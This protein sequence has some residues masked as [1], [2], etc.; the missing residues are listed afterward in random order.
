M[1]YLIEVWDV[2][3]VLNR[4]LSQ[5]RTQFADNSDDDTSFSDLLNA[6]RRLTEEKK[7]T[8]YHLE[9]LSNLPE[10][11]ENLL[12]TNVQNYMNDPTFIGMTRSTCSDYSYILFQ[13]TIYIWRTPLLPCLQ[14]VYQNSLSFE[15]C[16]PR[17]SPIIKASLICV[18]P[19]AINNTSIPVVFACNSYGS[20]FY[21]KDPYHEPLLYT[22]NFQ[23]KESRIISVIAML[24][25][26]YY[27]YLCLTDQGDIYEVYYK[28][29]NLIVN[30]KFYFST[31]S[32]SYKIKSYFGNIIGIKQ[33]TK[34]I[35]SPSEYTCL[36]PYLYAPL[37]SFI[38]TR[39]TFSLLSIHKGYKYIYTINLNID[40]QDSIST[41]CQD[42]SYIYVGVLHK[43]DNV[44]HYMLYIYYYLSTS[45]ETYPTFSKCISFPISILEAD[46][47]VVS[48][49]IRLF[50]QSTYISVI[51]PIDFVS[52]Y[53]YNL[54]T[55][56]INEY[57]IPSSPSTFLLGISHLLYP[58]SC[59]HL[60]YNH[61]DMIFV[62]E[63][64]PIEMP[65]NISE[66]L[67]ISTNHLVSLNHDYYDSKELYDYIQL[68]TD[69]IHKENEEFYYSIFKQIIQ[70]F[71]DNHKNS[72][73][74][75]LELF[76]QLFNINI[77]KASYRSLRSIGLSFINSQSTD[78]ESTLLQKVKI[79]Y[80][81]VQEF[82]QFLTNTTSWSHL[83]DIEKQ[84]LLSIFEKLSILK[85]FLTFVTENQLSDL[86]HFVLHQ[87]IT[88]IAPKKQRKNPES[89]YSSFLYNVNN[90]YRLLSILNTMLFSIYSLMNITPSLTRAR[91]SSTSSLT[92]NSSYN[93]SPLTIALS[94]P[95]SMINN[96][97]ITSTILSIFKL[98]TIIF[99]D[100][101][102]NCSLYS[103]TISF[104]N[105]NPNDLLPLY[106]S[107]LECTNQYI[108]HTNDLNNNV[109]IPMII[110]NIIEE[111][112]PINTIETTPLSISDSKNISISD[113]KNISI[114][115]SKNISIS[116][117]KNISISDSFAINN[118]SNMNTLNSTYTSLSF[119]NGITNNQ[120]T[121]ENNNNVDNNNVDNNNVDN[122]N[123]ISDNNISDNNNIHSIDIQNSNNS[124]LIDIKQEKNQP[125]KDIYLQLKEFI[126]ALLKLFDNEF[127][128]KDKD[129]HFSSL[130]NSLLNVSLEEIIDKNYP[131][132]SVTLSRKYHYYPSLYYT[133]KESSQPLK[134]EM[135]KDQQFAEYVAKVKSSN[136]V[137]TTM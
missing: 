17:D 131:A 94:P 83:T 91:S 93:N 123:I 98:Y 90:I 127:T 68:Y 89:F 61:G 53:T 20:I 50:P 100:I 12:R 65:S 84:R 62:S 133:L 110:E 15:V 85:S 22:I 124:T 120:N 1:I 77:F 137:N 13:N 35:E 8:N 129:I 40:E 70:I 76:I 60:L 37:Y 10:K 118:T 5:R 73:K 3:I 69:L 88:S 132:L 55:T 56:K 112:E 24:V 74:L 67:V 80:N 130:F 51:L 23:N 75:F 57:Y 18:V 117:S 97:Q 111:V 86:F 125:K 49:R 66:Q 128:K 101:Y 78:V 63:D 135:D 108:Y 107:L 28:A 54:K 33:E 14:D 106:I 92:S 105:Y 116:D 134:E 2:D 38:Y 79:K 48:H 59:L 109:S 113:S 47:P 4:K 45:P 122:N 99:D 72:A 36:L 52:I 136:N 126:P 82:L 95:E 119:N 43:V 46:M 115:D 6:K 81:K 42:S 121:I 19:D 103:N 31:S 64:I 21:W 7:N 26:K 104:I 44:Y 32:Y 29:N 25:N 39:S 11:I 41:L 102:K 96:N 27:I 58:Y 71:Y 30:Q 9:K 34:N 87:S 16:I 114:N